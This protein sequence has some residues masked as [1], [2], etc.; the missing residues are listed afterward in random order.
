MKAKM[1]LGLIAILIV[2]SSMAVAQ[3]TGPF[4]S[5]AD[6]YLLLHLD[7]DLTDSGPN[8]LTCAFSQIAADPD[9][10]FVSS[11]TGFGQCLNNPATTAVEGI[12][13]SSGEIS[14]VTG[15]FTYECWINIPSIASAPLNHNPGLFD[16]GAGRCLWRLWLQPNAQQITHFL[17]IYDAT[18][19]MSYASAVM[20]TTSGVWS[21]G[22]WHHMAVTMD[23]SKTGAYGVLGEEP[24]VQFFVDGVPLLSIAG[25]PAGVGPVTDYSFGSYPGEVFGR[26]WPPAAP[27]GNLNWLVGSA[28][29]ARFSTVDRYPAASVNDWKQY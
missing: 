22:N 2:P 24:P 4:T 15:P 3:P 17:T 27:G 12:I 11:M 7:G 10:M 29:E 16:R 13:C 26:P 9:P 21:W 5:D 14:E 23:T 19:T 8:G 6:T 28:D 18:G 20:D 25:A 1:I